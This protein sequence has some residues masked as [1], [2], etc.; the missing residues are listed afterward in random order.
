[1]YYL[2]YGF[3]YTVSLLP[4]WFLYGISDAVRWLLFRVFG[5]RRKI[6]RDNLKKAFPGKS[7]AEREE[8]RRKFERNFTD[9]FIETVKYFSASRDYLMKRMQGNFELFDDIQRKGQSCQ[10]Q[11]GHNFNWELLN[12]SYG[13]YCNMTALSVYLPLQ[14]KV[15]DRIFVKLRGRTGNKL[16]PATQ[17]SRAILPYRG[18]QYL[19]GLIA[20]QAPG[21]MANVWW[22]YFFG[23]PTPFTRGP[24]KNAMVHHLPVVFIHVTKWKRGHYRM[25]AELVTEDASM[26]QPGELTFLYRNFLEKVMQDHPDMWLWTHRRWK[27]RWEASHAERW[28]DPSPPPPIEP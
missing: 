1:M 17:I 4:M 12:L 23:Q 8:I 21:N 7:D 15:M 14:N 28:I 3:L 18:Q 22:M 9:T 25:H 16:L 10:V 2:V 24:E 26:Y 27:R 5:Y 20:D 6:V 13:C 11:L 19:L